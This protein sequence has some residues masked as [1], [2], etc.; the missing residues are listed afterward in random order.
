MR[1]TR[2][3]DFRMEAVP[4]GHILMLHNRDVPGVVGRVG[5]LLGESQ[6]NIA[7]LELGRE[8]VGGM[9]LSLFHVD[10]PVP[11][12]RARE[13]AH[14][15]ADRLGRAAAALSRSWQPPRS[16]APSGA[17]RA[18][19]RSSTCSPRDADIVVRYH[20]GNNAGH[21]L[22]VNGEKTV[23]HLI[24]SG[25]LHPGKVCVIGAGMVIDPAGA[26]RARSTRC[27]RAAISPRTAGCAS[28]SRRT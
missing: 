2:I 3:D 10:D 17:T 24:P 25:V 19:A 14:A 6:I 18:R 9:A 27:A 11:R 21:T 5:T 1:L 15:A 12:R 4:E 22:V 23:L 20:G 26:G 7:G 8:R 13:A 16:S 28:A